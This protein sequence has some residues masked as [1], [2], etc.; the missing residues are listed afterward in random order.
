[1]KRIT[2]TL[3]IGILVMLILPLSINCQSNDPKLSDQLPVIPIG[4]DD[5][6]MWDMLPYHKLG[7][8]AY[9][10]S[11]YDRNGNNRGADGSHFQRK[12]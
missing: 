1:M 9:M 5:Y 4:L 8:R 7:I 2:L 11:T 6:R 12:C 10:R 3:L